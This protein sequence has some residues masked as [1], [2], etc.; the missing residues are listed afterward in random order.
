VEWRNMHERRLR[1]RGDVYSD[2]DDEEGDDGEVDD[3]VDED[4]HGAG[5]EVAELDEVV[6]SG[7]LDEQPRREEH[8]QHHCDHD[9][10]P[11]RHPPTLSCSCCL[12]TPSEKNSKGVDHY[13]YLLVASTRPTTV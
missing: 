8:E 2:D 13:C 10:A 9:R 12:A 3:R 1:V 11:V 4:G 6:A 7:E 5:L